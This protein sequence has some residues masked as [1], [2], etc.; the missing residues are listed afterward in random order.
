MSDIMLY[1]YVGYFKRL[2]SSYG[3]VLVSVRNE[4]GGGVRG[5]DPHNCTGPWHLCFS[6]GPRVGPLKTPPP[7]ISKCLL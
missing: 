3:I 6:R 1:N 5:L 2:R 4:G 7:Q